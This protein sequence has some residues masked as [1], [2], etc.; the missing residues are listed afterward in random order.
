[1]FLSLKIGTPG[2]LSSKLNRSV[3][4]DYVRRLQHNNV[5]TQLLKAFFSR[6]FKTMSTKNIMRFKQ[7]G[8]SVRRYFRY[9]I[10]VLCT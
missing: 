7:T 2:V 9:I 5:L 4:E 8:M 10:G 1:M 3:N 6:D